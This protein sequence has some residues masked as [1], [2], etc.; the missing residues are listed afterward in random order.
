VWHLG[1]HQINSADDGCRAPALAHADPDWSRH[2]G[3]I[4]A[5]AWR[6]PG[7]PPITAR[8]R[9]GASTVTAWL[10]LQIR[11]P[12]TASLAGGSPAFRDGSCPPV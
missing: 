2:L 6:L 11:Y 4:W 8:Q 1:D 10:P 5:Q 3:E 12:I 7:D 9:P